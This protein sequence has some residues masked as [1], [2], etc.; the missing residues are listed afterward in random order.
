MVT[1]EVRH[2]IANTIRS[3]AKAM[4]SDTVSD[5]VDPKNVALGYELK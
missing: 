5:L 4:L 1:P 2:E 3:R